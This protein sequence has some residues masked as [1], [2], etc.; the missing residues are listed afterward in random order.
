VPPRDMLAGLAGLLSHWIFCL[1]PFNTALTVSAVLAKLLVAVSVGLVFWVFAGSMD[2]LSGTRARDYRRRYLT[3]RMS[4]FVGAVVFGCSDSLWH[5]AQGLTASTV[6]TFLTVLALNQLVKFLM[7]ARLLPVLV[8]LFSGGLL[9]AETPIGWLVALLGLFLSVRYL[10]VTP[11]ELWK[12]FLESESLQRTKWI[13]LFV[14]LVSVLAGVALEFFSFATLGG[15]SAGHMGLT[16]L[17]SCLWSGYLNFFVSAASVSGLVLFVL[18]VVVPFVIAAL[19]V[20]PSTDEDCYLPLKFSVVFIVSFA[21][22]AL[23]FLPFDFAWFWKFLPD[24]VASKQVAAFGT[25]LSAS[26]LTMCIFVLGIEVLCRDYE[27]IE[28]MMYHL[29]ETDQGNSDSVAEEIVSVRLTF[30]RTVLLLVPI[31]VLAAV[32]C[33]RCLSDERKLADVIRDCVHE[34]VDEAAA[35]K[36]IFT[37]GSLD[38]AI[39]IEVRSRGLDLRP[40]AVLSGNAPADA[41]LRRRAMTTVADRLAF[42]SDVVAALR[43]WITSHPEHMPEIAVQVAFEHFQANPKLRPVAYGILVRPVGDAAAAAAAAECAKALAVRL[44]ALHESGAWR[45]VKDLMLQDISQAIQFRLAVMCRVRAA[46]CD[47]RGKVAEALAETELADTLNAANPALLEVLSRQ[48]WLRRQSDADLTPREG[49]EI[50]LRRA[51]FTMARRFALQVLRDAPN[52]PDANFALGMGY[53]VADQMSRA[54]TYL[55]KVLK[56]QPDDAAAC[57]NLALVYLRTNRRAEAE[58]MARKAAELCPDSA[59]VKDTL[60]QVE[61]A[62]GGRERRLDK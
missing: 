38:D 62:K 19:L 42:G 59:E 25:L 37:D 43:G 47:A 12:P 58:R 39:R 14:F 27:H 61:K 32:A 20:V 52:D 30:G 48:D 56:A 33:G 31:F 6:T 35:A 18:L 3:V 4:A 5:S 13:F 10:S 36:Y 51:D 21:V 40:I 23:Q 9:C 16:G 45:R 7:T 26:T 2:L 60:R 17:P 55:D 49:L 50:A 29:F 28:A 46:E 22:A 53:Y 57:N 41:A 34:I 15:M 24:A 44:V 1:F 11:N 8:A 54:E